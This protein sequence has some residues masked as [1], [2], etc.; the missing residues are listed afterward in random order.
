MGNTFSWTTEDGID[1]YGIDW[2]IA[3]A[4][5]I[6]CIVHGLGEHIHR[7]EHAIDYFHKNNIA[8][9][10]YDR[11]GHGRSKGKRGHTISYDAFLDEV[12]HLLGEAKKRY[13]SLPVFLYGH[14]MGGNIV[15]NFTL[16]RKP[17][18]NG[19]I[20]TGA[21][22]RLAFQ[23][24]SITLA[25]GKMMRNIYPGFSQPNG[26]DVHLLSRDT[27]VVEAYKNDPYVHN[28][29]T[30]ITGLSMLEKADVLDHYTA[31]FPVPLLIMHGGADGIT[32]PGGSKD[33][34]ARV[35]GDITLKIWDK[36]YHEIHNEPEQD[37]VFAEI[38]G[39]IDGRV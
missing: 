29:V 27:K 15:L 20:S 7:Y 1:I 31:A 30:A 4:K 18:I 12:D 17:V 19:V 21:H 23:P 28:Q 35:R 32:S 16:D 33:F 6:V 22:I 39:W 14:S 2:P 8:V 26:L 37:L 25:L 13:P 24:S 9:I 3:N 36:F 38:L 5:A 34:A 10:G 11:R